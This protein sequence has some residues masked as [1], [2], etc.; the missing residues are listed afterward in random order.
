MGDLSTIDPK[1]LEILREMLTPIPKSM[2]LP[3]S[4]DKRGSSQ[5]DG[6]DSSE[7]LGKDLDAKG[8]KGNKKMLMPMKAMSN[9]SQWAA[10]NIDF[11]CKYRYKTDVDKFQKYRTKSI[12][13]ANCDTIKVKDHSAYI[14]VPKTNPGMVI[15]KSVFSMAAYWEVLWLKGGD[16]AKF[17]K[18]I[19]TKF[20][21]LTKGSW[22]PDDMKVPIDWVML[23]CQSP[24]GTD[25]AYTDNDGFRRP[26]MMGLWDLH[27]SNAINQMKLPMKSG[28]IDTKFCPLCTFWSTNN[29][30]LNNHVPKYYW[31][32]LCV[33][34]MASMAAMRQHME[35]A[36]RY[37]GKHARQKKKRGRI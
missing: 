9:P 33:G 20:P 18:A 30:M 19:S 11:V 35:Q 21:L 27:S 4:G 26:G 23:V 22:V 24:N 31:M 29:K 32:E 1:E 13:Q 37:E 36:H 6:S 25:V 34:P 17:D 5:L 15:E 12:D 7:M 28:V 16:V 10:D 3:G 8:I 14:S 2:P